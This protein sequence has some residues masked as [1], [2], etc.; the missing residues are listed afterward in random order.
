MKVE[1]QDW[2]TEFP[3]GVTVS[4]KDGTILYLNDRAAKT[5]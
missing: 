5:F 3:G 4:G 2:V 1:L